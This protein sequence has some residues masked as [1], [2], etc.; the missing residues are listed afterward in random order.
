MKK[1]LAIL[2]T[3]AICV[4]PGCRAVGDSP[5]VTEAVLQT[6]PALETTEPTQSTEAET[7]ALVEETIRATEATVSQETE[8]R[9]TEETVPV[10]Y[11]HLTLPTMA[12]V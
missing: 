6:Q 12:V 2:L 5:A 9:E 1:T 7:T 3:L 11:T 10:S 8:H 4:L